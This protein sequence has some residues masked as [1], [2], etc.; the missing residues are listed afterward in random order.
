MEKRQQA[1]KDYLKEH[2]N[3]KQL[4]GVGWDDI[5]RDSKS[6][7]LAPKELL[8]QVVPDIPA[9]FISNGH[10]SILV[11]SKALEIAGIDKNTLI[12]K[13]GLLNVIQRQESRQEF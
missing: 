2:P 7:G 13:A 8:D 1:I 6:R 5:K 4:R 3:I 12:R 10:H 11:N 9:V